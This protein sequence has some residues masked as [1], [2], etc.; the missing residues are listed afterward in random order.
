MYYLFPPRRDVA[1]SEG[2]GGTH[3]ASACDLRGTVYAGG[4]GDRGVVA[5]LGQMPNPPP[6]AELLPPTQPEVL[7]YSGAV[8]V[9]P[10][11]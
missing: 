3:W 5:I 4:C 2:R 6:G 8:R 11:D 7:S 9:A 1:L 10:L